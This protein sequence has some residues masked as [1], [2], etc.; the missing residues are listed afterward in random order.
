ME[1]PVYF[2]QSE[3]ARLVLGYLKESSH[4]L[5]Y[6]CFLKEC[7][8][9]AEYAAMLKE[10]IEY[11]TAIMGISLCQL[12]NEYAELKLKAQ[13]T[14]MYAIDMAAAWKQFDAVTRLL[15]KKTKTQALKTASYQQGQRTKHRVNKAPASQTDAGDAATISPLTTVSV[16]LPRID[17]APSSSGVSV[18]SYLTEVTPSGDN[19]PSAPKPNTEKQGTKKRTA[20]RRTP[21]QKRVSRRRRTTRNSAIFESVINTQGRSDSD[22]DAVIN[23]VDVSGSMDVSGNGN[24]SGIVDVSASGTVLTTQAPG[25]MEQPAAVPKDILNMGMFENSSSRSGA[26]IESANM[27]GSSVVLADDMQEKVDDVEDV[28]ELEVDQLPDLGQV[29]ETDQHTGTFSQH[30]VE[31]S[32]VKLVLASQCQTT[33]LKA[34][35][36]CSETCDVMGRSP[37]RRKHQPKRRNDSQ[38]LRTSDKD[39]AGAPSEQRDS[40]GSESSKEQANLQADPFPMLLEKIMNDTK[41]HERLAATINKSRFADP[42]QTLCRKP[43]ATSIIVDDFFGSPVPQVLSEDT[44]DGIIH[45]AKSDPLFDSLLNIFESE[46]NKAA[47]GVLGQTLSEH[48]GDSD[49]CMMELSQDGF[50]ATE[51]QPATSHPSLPVPSSSSPPQTNSQDVPSTLGP[52]PSPCPSMASP[53]ASLTS[54]CPS[55]CSMTSG[56][57]SPGQVLFQRK[58]RIKPI[59]CKPVTS[60]LPVFSSPVMHPLSPAQTPE[61]C[62]PAPSTQLQQ[63]PSPCVP[64]GPPGH[65]GLMSPPLSV[66]A[67]RSRTPAHAHQRSASPCVES[68]GRGMLS[69]PP[70]SPSISQSPGTQVAPSPHYQP[71]DSPFQSPEYPPDPSLMS[72]PGSHPNTPA[73]CINSLPSPQNSQPCV[74]SAAPTNVLQSSFLV[75][76]PTPNNG[77]GLQTST[78]TVSCVKLQPPVAGQP[79]TVVLSRQQVSAPKQTSYQGVH[80]NIEEN[81]V[82]NTYSMDQTN[83][84]QHISPVNALPKVTVIKSTSQSAMASSFVTN[85]SCLPHSK[86]AVAIKPLSTSAMTMATSNNILNSISQCPATACCVTQ[87][88]VIPSSVVLTKSCSCEPQSEVPT[89]SSALVPHSSTVK[90]QSSHVQSQSSVLLTKSSSLVQSSEVP[91]VSS[92]VISQFSTAP[93]QSLSV[94]TQSTSSYSPS[95]MDSLHTVTALPGSILTV[96]PHSPSPVL[97]VSQPVP[98]SPGSL[99]SAISSALLC[100]NSQMSFDLLGENTLSDFVLP[101]KPQEDKVETVVLTDTNVSL[102]TVVVNDQIY[103]LT[104]SPNGKQLILK[105]PRPM[106]DS[107]TSSY[108]PVTVVPSTVPQIRPKK[109]AV[110]HGSQKTVVMGSPKTSPRLSKLQE[111]VK[112]SLSPKLKT[113][114]PNILCRSPRQTKTVSLPSDGYFVSPNQDTTVTV[115]KS[116]KSAADDQYIAIPLGR[117]VEENHKRSLSFDKQAHSDSVSNGEQDPHKQKPVSKSLPCKKT[118]K[119]RIKMGG[120]RPTPKVNGESVMNLEVECP[121]GRSSCIMSLMTGDKLAQHKVK[122]KKKG[123][124]TR[125]NTGRTPLAEGNVSASL[126]IKPKPGAKAKNLAQTNEGGDSSI[127]A[128]LGD[129]RPVQVFGN[130]HLEGSKG[131]SPTRFQKFVPLTQASSPSVQISPLNQPPGFSA[132]GT[133][134]TTVG[135]RKYN[136]LDKQTVLG[137]LNGTC[138]VFLSEDSNLSSASSILTSASDPGPLRGGMLHMSSRR[139]EVVARTLSIIPECRLQGKM[140][141]SRK[142]SGSHVSLDVNL[143]GSARKRRKP[144]NLAKLNVDDFLSKIHQQ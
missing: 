73:P 35:S 124:N 130:K 7:K 48:V 71:A 54:P 55:V 142:R 116:S 60:A 23:V 12:L 96:R 29:Q 72:P 93:T 78:L 121:S 90:P 100:T 42:P 118:V 68:Q 18:G 128:P 91:T 56:T 45:M 114:K 127:S 57:G 112:Q 106:S 19:V 101:V 83:N 143:S 9:L 122:P 70:Q 137:G 132:E 3:V 38:P 47:A 27:H 79:Q 14:G 76:Q 5:T 40:S 111:I 46:G 20:K 43:V 66:S 64:P 22:S 51:S 105:N 10:G 119:A 139:R 81:G 21:V 88:V 144:P 39:G 107:Q 135:G 17:L 65:V 11:P 140:K 77:P 50:T 120:R 113:C 69:P 49:G 129:K 26:L 62:S 37:R 85:T 36:I 103:D 109:T 138:A 63:V 41:L 87:P 92:V 141:G 4:P 13:E 95:T 131:E 94:P 1:R 59:P 110:K 89:V 2:L 126:A 52:A 67:H 99:P 25:A 6:K 98:S 80:I 117:L 125:P 24:V 34:L 31:Q 8:Y 58:R 108:R 28:V 75:S 33:P 133:I 104:M 15:K 30:M 16:S 123:V 61:P 97:T 32:P 86:C 44:I 102:P 134:S 84:S 74:A 82:I 136:C 53:C 115:S